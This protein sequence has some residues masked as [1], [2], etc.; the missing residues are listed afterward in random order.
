MLRE[1]GVPKCD[2]C[3]GDFSLSK[4]SD[5]LVDV[6]IHDSLPNMFFC[7][8]SHGQD[9]YRRKRIERQAK[10]AEHKRKVKKKSLVLTSPT[11][12]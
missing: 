10:E 1:K 6:F 4:E 7:K 3:G 9:E 5:T 8:E 12:H 11:I 2:H